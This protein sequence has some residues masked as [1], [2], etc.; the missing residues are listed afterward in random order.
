M[1]YSKQK[2]IIDPLSNEMRNN[3]YKYVSFIKKLYFFQFLTELQK[4]L[5]KVLI[6]QMIKYQRKIIW[7][8]D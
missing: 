5:Q 2:I 6:L 7:N 8:P 3:F 4:F 1:Y